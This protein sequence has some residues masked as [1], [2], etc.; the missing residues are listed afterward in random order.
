MIRSQAAGIGK[1]RLALDG[2]PNYCGLALDGTV[3][4]FW[5]R[6]WSPILLV[7]TCDTAVIKDE[8]SCDPRSK[9]T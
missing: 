5:M 9:G 3:F 4:F 1:R 7:S 8:K 6:L 2:S